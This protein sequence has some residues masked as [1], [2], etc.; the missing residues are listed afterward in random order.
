MPVLRNAWFVLAVTVGTIPMASADTVKFE[1]VAAIAAGAINPPNPV[2]GCNRAKRDAEQKA[3]KAGT[4][5]LE[6]WDRLSVDSDCSLSTE[7][8]TGVGYFYIF[9]ASGNFTK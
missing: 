1:G 6:S 7:G 2:E 8:A 9:K 5:G 3:V 4:K